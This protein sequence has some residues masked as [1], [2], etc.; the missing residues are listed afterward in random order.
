MTRGSLTI[1]GTGMRAISDVT[2]ATKAA[3]EQADKVLYLLMDSLTAHYIDSLSR[4]AE[5]LQGCYVNGMPRLEAY[6]LMVEAMLAPVRAG[7]NV[8]CLFYG[9]PGIY[10]YP[11]H[12][13]IRIARAEGYQ[14]VMMPGI[15]T[16]DVLFADLGTDPAMTG[17]ASFE[18][19]DFLVRQ[20]AH[21]D[22]SCALVLWQVGLVGHSDYQTSGWRNIGLPMLCEKL[23]GIFGGT[24]VVTLYESALF[25]GVQSR[26]EQVRIDELRIENINPHTTMYVPPSKERTFD[27]KMVDRLAAL[28][29]D[30]I[31]PS[32]ATV[33]DVSRQG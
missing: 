1:A 4:D 26:I 9:H 15:S 33:I 13:A 21:V 20:S 17:L 19:T 22:P 6:N 5:S 28:T 18:A 8:C 24:H 27:H 16:E 14:A 32:G 23:E 10:V 7:L 25:T 12:L 2:L 3:I 31:P 29:T 30:R 11:S